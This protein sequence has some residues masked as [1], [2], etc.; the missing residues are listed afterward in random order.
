[1]TGKM[2]SWRRRAAERHS[3]HE[4]SG[5]TAEVGLY[6]GHDPTKLIR[7]DIVEE[8]SG[9]RAEKEE[10]QTLIAHGTPVHF[11]LILLRGKMRWRL[12]GDHAGTKYLIVQDSYYS[13]PS[14]FPPSPSL[15]HT[16]P[17]I[18]RAVSCSALVAFVG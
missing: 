8:R 1:M 17:P 7:D 2:Q 6:E 5:E 13:Y 18:L 12:P 14:F 16:E 9:F 3:A 4:S 15:P 11:W 10:W